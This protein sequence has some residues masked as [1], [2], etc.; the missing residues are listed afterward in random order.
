[1]PGHVSLYID[2]SIASDLC[3]IKIPLLL[4]SA[5]GIRYLGNV[6][7]VLC[8]II[9]YFVE[10]SNI[11]L[12]LDSVSKERGSPYCVPIQLQAMCR[13]SKYIILFKSQKS[14]WDQCLHITQEVELGKIPYSTSA[15]IN[16][17]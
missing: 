2:S 11:A 15:P 16:D 7:L 13:N 12:V 8:I 9:C 17:F 14:P 1:M 10:I 3:P 6:Y 5:P 4:L